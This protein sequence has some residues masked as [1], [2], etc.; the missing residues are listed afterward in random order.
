MN[1]INNIEVYSVRTNYDENSIQLAKYIKIDKYSIRNEINYISEKVKQ[2]LCIRPRKCLEVVHFPNFN[3]FSKY[4]R[5][6]SFEEAL[7]NT[8]F[9]CL[10]GIEKFITIGFSISLLV[11]IVGLLSII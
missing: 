5:N 1:K 3:F 8:G 9:L 10:N 4:G 6:P 11:L 7:R 2:K